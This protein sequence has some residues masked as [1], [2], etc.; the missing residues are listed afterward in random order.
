MRG[1]L[2]ELTASRCTG[3][4]R[5]VQMCPVDCLE[6][7][8]PLPWLPRP[9][10]CISCTVCAVICPTDAIRMQKPTLVILDPTED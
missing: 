10:D 6:M 2:P 8:G 9:L 5:C 3:C 4:E 1:E 7:A